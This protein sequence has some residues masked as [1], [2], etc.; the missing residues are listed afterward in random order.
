MLRQLKK[1]LQKL[2][3]LQRAR[4]LMGFFKTGKGQY[5]E[6]DVFWGITVPLVRKVARQSKDLSIKNLQKL[7]NSKIHEFRLVALLILVEKY[8]TADILGKKKIVDFYLKNT[9]NINNWDLVDLSSDKIL[10]DYLLNS[11]KKIIYK[12]AKSANIWERRIAMLATFQFIKNLQF[13]DSLK[14]AQILLTDPHDLIQ[15]AVG[16]MLREIGK[17]NLEVELRFLDKHFQKMPR[18]T[19]RYAIERLKAKEKSFYMRK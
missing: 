4:F 8:K 12:L 2:K 13:E 10:G 5:G 7:L 14:I 1:D 9:K 18:T 6:G 19:L 15:K 17:R 3:D 16:W 11:D